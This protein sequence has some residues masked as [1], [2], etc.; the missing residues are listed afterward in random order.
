M[1]AV[2]L[3][4]VHSRLSFRLAINK[5][6]IVADDVRRVHREHDLDLIQRLSLLPYHFLRSY[7]RQTDGLNNILFVFKHGPILVILDYTLLPIDP[8]SL[9]CCFLE[10]FLIHYY[11]SVPGVHVQ[12]RRLEAFHAQDRSKGAAA[13]LFYFLEEFPGG[14]N[15]FGP[16][17]MLLL[18]PRVQTGRGRMLL[19][20]LIIIIFVFAN[21]IFRRLSIDQM[22]VAGAASMPLEGLFM[23]ELAAKAF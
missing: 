8:C 17:D 3:D 22:E 7:L 18:D 19:L 20:L 16:L 23:I 14:V 1:S 15:D 21:F 10:S 9:Q 2:L 13:Q 4:Y 5:A 12:P 11:P 6:I